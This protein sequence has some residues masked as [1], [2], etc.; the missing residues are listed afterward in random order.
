MNGGAKV[1]ASRVN[2][3][4]ASTSVASWI[5]GP[6]IPSSSRGFLVAGKSLGQRSASQ[7]QGLKELVVSGSALG[8]GAR[9]ADGDRFGR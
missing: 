2:S 3:S 5:L 1:S 7:Q 4:F 9:Y 8:N 6:I